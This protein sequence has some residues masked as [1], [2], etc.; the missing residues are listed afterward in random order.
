MP[1]FDFGV[2]DLDELD[3]LRGALDAIPCA[4]LTYDEWLAVGMACKEAGLGADEWDAWSATDPDRYEVGVCAEKWETFTDEGHGGGLLANMARAHGWGGATPTAAHGYGWDDEVQVSDGPRQTRATTPAKPTR[5][6]AKAEPAPVLDLAQLDYDEPEGMDGM[7]PAEQLRAFLT[8]LYEPDELINVVRETDPHGKPYGWG[9]TDT[10]AGMAERAGEVLRGCDPKAGAFIRCNPVCDAE[11]LERLQRERETSGRKRRKAYADEHVTAY[12]YALVES[13][14]EDADAMTADELRADK[15]RQLDTVRRL[16]LPCAAIVDSGHKSIH[17]LVRINAKDA[18]EYAQRVTR[19]YDVCD[20]NGLPVD[21]ACK[22]PARLVRMAGAARGEGAQR[23]IDVATSPFSGYAEWLEWVENRAPRKDVPPAMLADAD[24]GNQEPEDATDEVE[25]ANEVDADEPNQG[26][27]EPAP[28]GSKKK[29]KAPTQAQLVEFMRRDD[30]LRGGFGTNELDGGLYV[31]APLPW[32]ESGERRR[33]T[34]A[35]GELLF[36]YAQGKTGTN[37]R[38]NVQGAFTIMAAA[39]TFNPIADMLDGLP[40]WDGKQR[41]DNLL[42]VVFKCRNNEYTRAVSHTFMRGAVLRGYEPGCKFDNVLTLIGPQGCGKTYG[43]R[44]MAMRDELLCESVTD[45]TDHKKT[46]EQTAGKWLCELGELE[47][48]TGRRLTGVKQA[49][50]MQTVTVRLPYTKH[51][52]D[53][54][55]S[56]AFVATTNEHA[57][58]ADR[59]GNRR[60]WPIRCADTG[61]TDKWTHASDRQLRAYIA[62]AWAEVRDEYK[63][64]CAKAKDADEF[65]RLY[66]TTLTPEIERKAESMRDAASVEDTRVGVIREWLEHDALDNGTTRVC[67]RMVAERALGV[68]MGRQRGHQLTN[69]VSAILDACPNWH[70]V[71]KQRVAGYGTCRA[72]EHRPDEGR[73]D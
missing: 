37:S 21:H 4:Q 52:V 56:C 11:T 33:W 58:L 28:S 72:W 42:A 39:Q 27:D 61:R 60:F 18:D 13:D 48:M 8:A 29:R 22:N 31:R 49:L 70:A 73:S 44:L 23:L 16:R 69:E 65:R 30:R 12:R 6:Q 14:P 26:E 20:A 19:L 71:G 32:D 2:L 53:L 54:P 55:R 62:R 5:R 7:E 25:D 40:E 57:F 46:A 59:T 63:A 34:D 66:P 15:L 68:D 41:A 64:A 45:L 50:S 36:I 43:T 67:A 35:D 24:E 51:A 17:A 1:K 9:T 3:R 47:G 38:R 10:R